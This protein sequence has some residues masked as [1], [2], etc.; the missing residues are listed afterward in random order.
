MV[1]ALLV[2]RF[3][4]EPSP[5]ESRVRAELR[6]ALSANA[7]RSIDPRSILAGPRGRRSKRRESA[8]RIAVDACSPWTYEAL[9]R[10][11]DWTRFEATLFD[12]ATRRRAQVIS[13]LY[14]D[15]SAQLDNFHELA[16][17]LTLGEALGCDAVRFDALRTRRRR[18]AAARRSV[19]SPDH[20]LH[21]C[22]LE[23]LRDP[24]FDRPSC[25][26]GALAEVRERA[27]ARRLPS[28]DE[29][30]GTAERC[31]DRCQTLLGAGEAARCCALSAHG[32][33]MFPE[34][35]DLRIIEAA[36][37]ESLGFVTQ[38]TYRYREHLR[39]RPADAHVMVALG[40]ALMETGETRRGVRTLVSAATSTREPAMHDMV[41]RYLARL[42]DARR[43][44]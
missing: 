7:G 42:I 25:D 31:A 32:R 22:F 30:V 43:A 37:L 34:C 12:Q 1:L 21:E 20:P 41:A 29:P 18:G 40:V 17:I 27:F 8:V 35:G 2:G 11:T 44:P 26:L 14:L 33:W 3:M 9:Y 36:A 5:H 13:G 10:E 6:E 4:E 39:A 23:T 38:A 16:A 15:V 19:A 28:D 24:A